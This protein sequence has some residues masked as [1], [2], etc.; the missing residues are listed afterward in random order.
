MQLVA[1]NAQDLVCALEQDHAR[2]LLLADNTVSA[3]ALLLG[4]L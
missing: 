4:W 1:A 3:A 2:L